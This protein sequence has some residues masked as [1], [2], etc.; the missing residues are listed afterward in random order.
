MR[1]L[2]AEWEKHKLIL[3]AFPHKNTDWAEDGK[4]EEAIVPF[5]RISQAISYSQ[6]LYILCEDRELIESLFCSTKNITFIEMDFN[7]TWTRD[8]GALSIEVDGK[9]KLLDFQFDG[10]GGKFEAKLDNLVNRRLHKK[11]YFGTTPL[12]SI[13]Y[14]LEGGSIDT[15]G[16]GT[17][18]TTKE[19]LCNPNRNG[20]LMQDE[21]EKILK[22]HLGAKRVLWLESGFLEGD[23]TNSHIDT[24]ARFVSKDTIIYQSCYD[25]NDLHF[26]ALTNMKKELKSL[27]RADGGSYNLVPLPLPEAKF[28]S[29]GNRLP[30][31]YAN[32]LITNHALLYPTYR[33]KSDRR[34]G[35]IFRKLFPDRE[36]IPIECSKLI[37]QG[38]S[39]HCST[40]Q[41]N[42]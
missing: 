28:D 42:Y 2:K 11:G 41:I 40:M 9:P 36:I 3:M 10:W 20:G 13:E 37:E 6:S 7:D 31:T 29:K 35:E 1:R 26:N 15:D 8:Y 16:E 18:L 32:F 4:L 17:I 25:S 12:E 30:A 27:K 24:L 23:D 21:V 5:L 33:D 34:V 14:V 38:G 22:K 19:C 39:L